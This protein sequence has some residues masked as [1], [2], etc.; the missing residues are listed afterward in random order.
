MFKLLTIILVLY[1]Y[2]LVTVADASPFTRWN[3]D[4]LGFS[5]DSN[6]FVIAE[7]VTE[8]GTNIARASIRVT[9]VATS[10]CVQGGCLFA[11][12]SEDKLRT[13]RDVLKEVY[14]KTWKLRNRLKLIPLR[15]GYRAKGPVFEDGCHLAYYWYDNQKIMVR[16]QQQTSWPQQASVQLE[17]TI[18]SLQKTVDSLNNYREGAKK[19]Q[20]GSLFVSPNNRSLAILVYVFYKTVDGQEVRTFVQTATFF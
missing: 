8:A 18:D 6:S 13:E 1:T 2:V 7:S 14:K 12:G 3:L 9:D 11:S 10:Q 4:M 20:L 16:M 17:V 15:G 5:S 19:Y